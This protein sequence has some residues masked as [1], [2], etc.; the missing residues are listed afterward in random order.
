ML[1]LGH[2]KHFC[3]KMESKDGPKEGT[4]DVKRCGFYV[5]RK[6]RHCRMIPAKGNNFCAEHL[7]HQQSSNVGVEHN[8]EIV[9]CSNASVSTI[10]YSSFSFEEAFGLFFKVKI[11]MILFLF[12]SPSFLDIYQK[13]STMSFGPKSVSSLV[14]TISCHIIQMICI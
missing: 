2:D 11:M 4:A 12:V 9:E 3:L 13:K 5:K 14:L 7:C 1:K 8:K 6:R 10:L